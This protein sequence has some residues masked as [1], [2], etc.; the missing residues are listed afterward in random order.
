MDYKEQLV[1][2]VL[3]KMGKHISQEQFMILNQVL[4]SELKELNIEKKNNGLITYDQSA[5]KILQYFLISK[6][7]SGC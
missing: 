1:I 5:A 2:N 4:L 3:D 7:A 6:K